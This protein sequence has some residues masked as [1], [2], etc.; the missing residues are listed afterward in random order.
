MSVQDNE[1]ASQ[2]DDGGP[3]GKPEPSQDAEQ[4]AADMMRAYEDRPTVVLP[5]SGGT[6]SGTA[7]NDWLDQ[8]GNPKFNS[9]VPGDAIREQF[10]KDKA[11]NVELIKASTAENKGESR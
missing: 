3:A 1:I 5:G 6:I 2:H 11:L 9:E 4:R 8:D 10:E 7:V